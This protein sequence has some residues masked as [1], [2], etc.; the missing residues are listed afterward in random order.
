MLRV[1]FSRLPLPM[2]GLYDRVVTSC[3]GI[4]VFHGAVSQMETPGGG[5][6]SLDIPPKGVLRVVT[7]PE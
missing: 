2:G 6:S 7:S 5:G 4:G 1:A 3:W